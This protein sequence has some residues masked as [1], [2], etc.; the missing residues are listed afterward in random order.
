MKKKKKMIIFSALIIVSV[1]QSH[2]NVTVASHHVQSPAV[3][4]SNR[5]DLD[6]S[7]FILC[8]EAHEPFTMED[9]RVYIFSQNESNRYV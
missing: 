1:N 9:S 4:T 8:A 2:I 6:S 5:L 7:L 3:E